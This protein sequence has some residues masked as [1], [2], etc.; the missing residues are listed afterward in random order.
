M[1]KCRRFIKSQ[2]VKAKL[3][4]IITQR[5]EMKHPLV[6]VAAAIALLVAGCSA[7]PPIT[8]QTAPAT[9]GS[10]SVAAPT[11]GTPN[12]SAALAPGE[13]IF[14][15]AYKSVGKIQLEPAAPVDD[16]EELRDIAKSEPVTYVK[17]RVDNRKG[18]V[19]ANMYSILI[20]DAV[21]KEYELKN[22]DG[23]VDAWRDAAGDDLPVETY[24][25]FID[26]GNEYRKSAQPGAV[27]D[28]VMVGEF[29]DF[30]AEFAKVTVNANGGMDPVPAVPIAQK[31]LMISSQPWITMD[32]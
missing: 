8:E 29:V 23:I 30:P 4:L 25:K 32:F 9:M 31:D 22:A 18:E 15:S 12:G 1:G 11:T 16:L 21:G 26:V 2:R 28:F 7:S 6:A 27:K 14:V 3:S 19:L 5:G 24:N 20:Y 17:V 13:F 10:Q